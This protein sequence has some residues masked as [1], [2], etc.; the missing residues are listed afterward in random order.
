VIIPV[1][2]YLTILYFTVYRI[3]H[4]ISF[5]LYLIFVHDIKGTLNPNFLN[6]TKNTETFCH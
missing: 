6:L 3:T 2:V 5:A 4:K 1:Y